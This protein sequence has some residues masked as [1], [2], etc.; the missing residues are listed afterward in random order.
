MAVAMGCGRCRFFVVFVMVPPN[1]FAAVL[2]DTSKGK[3]W[4]DKGV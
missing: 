4:H 1:L 2:E 3:Q